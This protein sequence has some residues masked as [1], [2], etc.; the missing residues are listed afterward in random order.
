M[1]AIKILIPNVTGPNNIGD[2][3]I[4]HVLIKG[5]Y[6]LFT[7]KVSIT[8]LSTEPKRYK[9][10][11]GIDQSIQE[12]CIGDKNNTLEKIKRLIEL[13]ISVF[14]R[15]IFIHTHSYRQLKNIISYYKNAE[16]I[17]FTGGGYFRSKKGLRQII[18]LYIIWT[19]FYISILFKKKFIVAPISFGPFAY[20]WQEKISADILSKAQLVAIRDVLSYKAIKKYN[21]NNIVLLTDL[22]LFLS[23]ISQKKRLE[24][25][26][27]GITLRQWLPNKEQMRVEEEIIKALTK[28]AKK[29]NII[30]LPIVQVDTT[31][32]PEDDK[33]VLNRIRNRLLENNI[34][35]KELIRP[36]DIIEAC[37][38]Y[39]SIDLLMGMRMHSNLIAAT[40]YTP[41]ITIAYEYKAEGIAKKLG[42]EKYCIKFK[43]ITEE[44]LL[45]LLYKSMENRITIKRRLKQVVDTIQTEERKSWENI[46]KSFLN[47]KEV[48]RI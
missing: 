9:K 31:Y 41:F 12:W 36:N 6:K 10:K 18:Y 35:V 34:T 1:K 38:V 7:T 2:Q 32:K 37:N 27:L 20:S 25:M 39:G 45:R 26:T 11:N 48:I 23:H 4:L 40:Q 24:K 17:I 47:R 28:F 13:T 8:I 46:C 14:T 29:N 3:A 22:S 5:I 33:P 19:T 16:F 42:L 21:S 44:K 30:I 15:F 43:D